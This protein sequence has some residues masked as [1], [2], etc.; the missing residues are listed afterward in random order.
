M[1]FLALPALG[2]AGRPPIAM[3]SEY[4]RQATQDD[5]TG[6]R[7]TCRVHV[8]AVKDSRPDAGSMGEIGGRAVHAGDEAAWL[9]SGIASLG[10]D[11][12]LVFVDG[13]ADVT[14]DAELLKAYIMTLA[15]DAKAATVVV[16]VGFGG[17][18]AQLYRGS[19]AGT[20]WIGG[21]DETR[22]AFDA[23]LAEIL[24]SLRADIV[25]RCGRDRR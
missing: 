22:S 17:T 13:P 14:F 1:P 6:E 11:K 12:H 3:P 24:K 21:E 18:D 16:R 7:G 15:R 4:A 9:R 8:G 23:S 19:D 5:L 20:D 25:A 10:G 2:C